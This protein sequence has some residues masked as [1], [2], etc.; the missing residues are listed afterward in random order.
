MEIPTLFSAGTADQQNVQHSVTHRNEATT[1]LGFAVRV[2][3]HAFVPVNIF[4]VHPIKLAGVP[5]YGIPHQ[6]APEPRT[7]HHRML[8]SRSNSRLL[9]FD[10]YRISA[11]TSDISSIAGPARQLLT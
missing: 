4:N 9:Q 7:S 5:H 10:Y 6:H 2:K 1:F 3:D 11:T 8:P